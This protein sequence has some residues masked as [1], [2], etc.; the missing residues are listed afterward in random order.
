MEGILVVSFGTSHE[1]AM[2]SI[3]AV[4]EEIKKSFPNCTIRRAFTSSI[5]MKKLAK[6]GVFIDDVKTA[7]DKMKKEGISKVLVQPTHLIEGLEYEKTLAAAREKR[8]E[9]EEIK[10]GLPL[11]SCEEDIAEI[12]DV[13]QSEIKR[14]QKECLVLM[15][16]GS[17]HSADGVYARVQKM[18][19]SKGIADVFVC[20]VEGVSS[21]VDVLSL[22]KGYTKVVLAPLMLVA[23]DHALNDMA[24]EE[25][26]LK[27]MFSNDGFAVRTIIRGLGE[28]DGIKKMYVDHVRDA[29]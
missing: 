26:S 19:N 5:I 10:V 4:E 2:K 18:F 21:E 1:G 23:G 12:V 20:T 9:F 28:Y 3:C 17:E 16:H 27:T 8:S 24:G 29:K 25:D 13:I 15:G 14:E 6:N 22:A 7:L 11:L